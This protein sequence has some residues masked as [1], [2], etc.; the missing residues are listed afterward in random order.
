MNNKGSDKRIG[1]GCSILCR[2]IHEDVELMLRVLFITSLCC[3]RQSNRYD[4]K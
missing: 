2:R 4:P 1:C 3:F